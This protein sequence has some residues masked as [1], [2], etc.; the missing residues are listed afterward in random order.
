MKG[1]FVFIIG[2]FSFFISV[3]WMLVK[4][5][6]NIAAQPG[7]R[8]WDSL[9]NRL[10]TVLEQE[11][12]NL[13]PWDG[14]D[15]MPLLSLSNLK[16]HSKWYETGSTRKGTI[17]TIYQ[18]P[19]IAVAEISLGKSKIAVARTSNQEF[20]YRIKDKDVEIWV[21]SQ[22]YA[23]LSGGA[24]LASGK[25]SKLLAQIQANNDERSLPVALG[26]QTTLTLSNP[27]LPPLSPNPRAMLLLRD[28]NAEEET[29]ALSLAIL[30]QLR[31]DKK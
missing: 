21:N 20:V 28:L 24:L 10:R 7:S 15:L 18:E 4:A 11:K 31:N 14:K 2:I 9:V 12:A 22:P 19:V 30:Y 5:F 29:A 6:G 25:N 13:I 27:A 16:N 1:L 3:V 8:Q 17:D 26:N 23:V